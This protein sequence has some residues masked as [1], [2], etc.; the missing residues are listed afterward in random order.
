MKS[1]TLGKPRITNHNMK[2]YLDVRKDH[3]L[4][5]LLEFLCIIEN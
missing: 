4:S 2:N 1:C 3:T 5:N